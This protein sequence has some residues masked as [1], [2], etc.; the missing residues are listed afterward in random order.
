MKL[1]IINIKV[2]NE[3]INKIEKKIQADWTRAMNDPY[4]SRM[5]LQNMSFDNVK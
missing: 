3:I 4:P 1:N 2:K 5:Q